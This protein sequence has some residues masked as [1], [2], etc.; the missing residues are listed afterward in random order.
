MIHGLQMGP[1]EARYN[2][3]K[4]ECFTMEAFEDWY[5]SILLP[6]FQKLPKDIPKVPMGDNL[7]SH[8]QGSLFIY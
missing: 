4:S 7:A 3:T 1:K 2:R 8:V 6:Y 5:L